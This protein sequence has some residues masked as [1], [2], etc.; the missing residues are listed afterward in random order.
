MIA[1]GLKK[2][3]TNAMKL[4]SEFG[5]EKF[6]SRTD[7]APILG[8]TITPASA[9]L[10]KLAVLGITESV[11]GLGKGKYRFNPQFFK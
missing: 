1:A 9:L 3:A 6:F 7:A 2:T 8:I 11:S 4:F 10:K 5:F